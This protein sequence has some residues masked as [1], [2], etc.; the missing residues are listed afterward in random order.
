MM[1]EMYTALANE[2]AQPTRAIVACHLRAATTLRP[3]VPERFG[4]LLTDIEA[5]LERL[6]QAG[7]L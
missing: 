6:D 3:G 1:T 7:K 5:A 4:P 2:P